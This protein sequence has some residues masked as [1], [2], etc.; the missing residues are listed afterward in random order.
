MKDF[1]KGFKNLLNGF[2][3]Y[4]NKSGNT[5]TFSGSDSTSII[6][7][8][9]KTT[10]N[11]LVDA[12]EIKIDGIAINL[13][14]FKTKISITIEGNVNGDVSSVVSPISVNGNAKKVNT[15]SGYIKINHDVNGDVKTTSGNITV[16]GSIKGDMNTVSGAIVCESPYNSKMS[17]LSGDIKIKNNNGNISL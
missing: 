16:D 13:D 14:N 5:V 15:T 10:I 1:I 4:A 3:D 6:T 12:E 9:G 7:I 2:T 17:T 11:G 8:N